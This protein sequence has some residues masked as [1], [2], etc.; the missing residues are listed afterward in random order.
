MAEVND[1]QV[2]L[3]SLRVA[4]ERVSG[5]QLD[6]RYRLEGFDQDWVYTDSQYRRATY[7]NLAHGHYQF[8][9]EASYDGQ[10]WHG[11][12]RLAIEVATPLW[13]SP[14]AKAIYSLPVI[15]LLGGVG[16]V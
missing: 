8:T 5:Q 1:W 15:A 13:L 2:E 10:H 12:R 6:Y 14:W 7:T 11:T 9:V 4:N 16:F 3:I